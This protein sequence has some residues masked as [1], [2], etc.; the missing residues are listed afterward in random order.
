MSYMQLKCIIV[1][2]NNVH[3][4]FKFCVISFIRTQNLHF[5]Q[6]SKKIVT[7]ALASKLCSQKLCQYY[8]AK[9]QNFIQFHAVESEIELLQE[10]RE[11][12][13]SSPPNELRNPNCFIVI[14]YDIYVLYI[15]FCAISSKRNRDLHIQKISKKK[16]NYS[17]TCQA[18]FT[19][20]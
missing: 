10:F 12:R 14:S 16:L 6:N 20:S 4:A 19:K 5:P 7:T 18:I 13:N 8:L 1:T 15:N 11:K 2:S 17:D 9:Q 3:L